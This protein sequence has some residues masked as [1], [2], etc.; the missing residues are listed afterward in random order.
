MAAWVSYG[1]VHVLKVLRQASRP[2]RPHLLRPIRHHG[3]LVQDLDQE[4]GVRQQQATQL[5]LCSRFGF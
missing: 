5:V 2:W 1:G 3:L 4:N